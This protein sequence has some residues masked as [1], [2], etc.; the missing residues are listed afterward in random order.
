MTSRRAKRALISAFVATLLLLAIV[1]AVA[2]V[3]E[4][5]A[6][7][8]RLRIE[9]GNFRATEPASVVLQP[10]SLERTRSFTARIM[11][12]AEASLAPEVSGRV[13]EVLVEIGETVA[14]GAPLLR[15]ND[16]IASLAA[17]AA[18]ERAAETARRLR[19]AE[20]L[21]EAQALS[22]T[23][24]LNLRS[25]ARVAE[26]ERDSAQ[27]TLARHT[28][29]APFDGTISSRSA[30]PGLAVGP[31][32]RV[33]GIEDLSRLRVVFF[34][35]ERELPAFAPGKEVK[36]QRTGSTRP[37][38]TARVH[39]ASASAGRGTGLFRVEAELPN[40][41]RLPSG[42]TAA[43]EAVIALYRDTIFVPT[44]AVRYEGRQAFVL[45]A[46]KNG[47]ERVPVEIGPE[48]DAAHPVISGLNAGDR[49]IIR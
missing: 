22:E 34:V 42:V 3:F 7:E 33:I 13:D 9:R 5:R 38:Q 17:A 39:I 23:D 12:W 11:P 36:V 4:G 46:T 29:R 1:A 31:M 15:L 47:E 28:I 41:E 6:L 2:R 20:A 27:E 48:L 24:L 49:I 19:E 16:R 25:A 18:S 43:V 14:K 40:P 21:R 37:P 32:D 30:D 26:I 44:A 8:R 35:S 10:R 45:R